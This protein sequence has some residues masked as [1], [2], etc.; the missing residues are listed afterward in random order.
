MKPD[1]KKAAAFNV[2][3]LSVIMNHLRI[4]YLFKQKAHSPR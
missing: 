2:Q 1:T 4:A 3:Q